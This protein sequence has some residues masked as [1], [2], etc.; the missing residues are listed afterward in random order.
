MLFFSESRV[1]E[2]EEAER[3]FINIEREMKGALFSK[4]KGRTNIPKE[5]AKLLN[6]ISSKAKDLRRLLNR[7]DGSLRHDLDR[8]LGYGLD[9]AFT[10]TVEGQTFTDYEAASTLQAVQVIES[11]SS[12]MACHLINEYGKCY[13]EHMSSSLAHSWPHRRFPRFNT[14]NIT[15]HD[16]AFINY[17][18]IILEEESTEKLYKHVKRTNWY[19]RLQ[20]SRK[21]PKTNYLD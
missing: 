11:D 6:E 18:A 8:R 10:R 14:I 3:L 7:L 4:G 2:P 9:L 5:K 16:C 15:A 20:E 1:K 17:L 12:I 19:G 21:Q 13:M